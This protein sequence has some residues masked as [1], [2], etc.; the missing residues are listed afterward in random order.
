MGKKRVVKQ[1][2]EEVLKE[3]EEVESKIQKVI[4]P[5][6][7]SPKKI[8]RGIL[9]IASTYNNTYLTLTDPEGN[10]LTWVS[11]G[12]IGFK[13]TKKGTPYAAS[14]AAEVMAQAIEKLRLEEIQIKVKGIGTGRE[15]ALRTLATKGI[16]II[17]IEDITPIPHNGCKR[18]KPRRV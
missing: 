14:K 7:T 12:K 16:N 18:P 3:K 6:K 10:V 1:T 15:S 2:V 17:S 5:S 13:G 4:P 8:T 9:Y 11:A